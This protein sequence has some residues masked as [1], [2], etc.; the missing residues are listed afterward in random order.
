MPDVDS[1]RVDRVLEVSG[2]VL[3]DHLHTGA[4]VLGNLMNIGSLR[5]A[6]ADIDRDNVEELR[7][8]EFVFVCV[9]DGLGKKLIVEKLEE[10]G[11]SFI[12]VGMGMYSGDDGLGGSVRVTTSTPTQ[13]D[14]VRSHVS[15]A[16]GN[17]QNE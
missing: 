14:H 11:I 12:D 1:R 2:V 6:Q 13:R 4:T 16:D 9:D 3:F 7:A 17:D 10:Y 5:K 8:M 15:F